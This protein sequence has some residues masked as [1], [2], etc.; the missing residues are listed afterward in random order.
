LK[1]IKSVDDEITSEPFLQAFPQNPRDADRIRRDALFNPLIRGNL[2]SDAGKAMAVKVSLTDDPEAAH[3]DKSILVAIE[4]ILTPLSGAL[5]QAFQIGDPYLRQTI[6]DKIRSDQ[7]NILP[8]SL[9][10]LLLTLM[11]TLRR[12]NGAIIP[13]VTAAISIIWTL[14]FMAALDVPINVMTSIVPALLIIIG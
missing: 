12:L 6:T 13:L 5:T 10:A 9:I 14:V 2:L 3:S 1:N 7:R 8:R 11:L 4:Q